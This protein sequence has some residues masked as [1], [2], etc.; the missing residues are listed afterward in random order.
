MA[1]AAAFVLAIAF[2]TAGCGQDAGGG[3]SYFVQLNIARED[4]YVGGGLLSVSE[5]MQLM[6][7]LEELVNGLEEDFSLDF[8]TS[9]LS[10]INQAAAG[11]TVSVGSGTAV[12]LSLARAF[13]VMTS[14]KF[15]PAL[16]P[17]TELWGFAPSDAGHY[18]DPRGEPSSAEI[19]KAL[20]LSDF[21]LFSFD[22]AGAV[23][24]ESGAQLDFGGIAK[25]YMCDRV[26]S[27]IR[28]KYSGQTV[29]GIV[30]LSSSNTALLGSRRDGEISRGYNIGIENPRRLTAGIS[31]GL[32]LVGLSDAAV[33]TS[34]DNYRFYVDGGKI[35][36]HIIDPETGKPADR[37]I[38]SVTVV[39]PEAAHPYAG[40]LADALS[41]AAF[42]MPLTQAAALFEGLAGQGIGAV[43]ITN[44]FHYYA[45]GSLADGSVAKV[46][47]R[48][49][50]AA[51]CNEYLGGNY[52][53]AGIEDIFTEGDAA[54]AQDEFA[55]CDEEKAYIARAEEVTG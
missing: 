29:D 32:Y 46:M 1:P 19:E 44:D 36:S 51:Y 16:F 37:G 4:L 25:G 34:A 53:L 21:S 26:V 39:V 5:Y 55:M 6:E 18:S 40:A 15:S 23:K 20:A 11:E 42:C 47:N 54:L 14:G 24:T 22:G 43:I 7:E 38:I 48:K 8:E 45:A 17:L 33:T 50:Y 12:L 28:Q 2:F 3:H 10:R 35:Y 30:S 52:D 13:S 31:T 9:D 27:Y 49:A 41:T